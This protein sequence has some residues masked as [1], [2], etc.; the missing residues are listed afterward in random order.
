[1]AD[2]FQANKQN[3]AKHLKAIFSGG[4]LAADSVVNHWLTTAADE[5]WCRLRKKIRAEL[6][7]TRL[8][9]FQGAVSHPFEAGEHRK[10][11]I[12][13]VDDRGIESLRVM[14][15]QETK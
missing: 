9:T 15:L 13:I 1:M 12:K 11:T 7:E 2:L 4:E 10:V 8:S 5:G 6:A 3:I 14:P